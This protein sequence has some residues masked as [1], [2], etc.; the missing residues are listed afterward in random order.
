MVMAVAS[1]H[2]QALSELKLMFVRTTG[3][4]EHSG[5]GGSGGRVVVVE[6]VDVDVV[7]VEVV[8][9]VEVVGGGESEFTAAPKF[10]LGLGMVTFP[11]VTKSPLSISFDFTWSGVR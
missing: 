11:S 7:V 5:H 2:S 4:P 6:V 10:T 9:V 1:L 3:L 8:E